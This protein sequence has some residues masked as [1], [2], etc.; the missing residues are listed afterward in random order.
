MCPR[1]LASKSRDSIPTSPSSSNSNAMLLAVHLPQWS[2][3]FHQYS[4]DTHKTTR[5]T[6]VLPVQ[7]PG[8][9]AG[10]GLLGCDLCYSDCFLT[11]AISGRMILG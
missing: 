8:C 11:W 3:G 9:Q 1:S 6:A 7:L 4:V 10:V 2:P 5:S